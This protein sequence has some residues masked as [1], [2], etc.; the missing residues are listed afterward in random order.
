MFYVYILKSINFSTQS[1]VGFSANLKQRVI[2]H[3]AGKSVHTNKYKP[4]KVETYFAFSSEEKAR[5]FEKYLKN[6]SKKHSG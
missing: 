1:Y 3:N 5:N 2:D 6:T 4:W